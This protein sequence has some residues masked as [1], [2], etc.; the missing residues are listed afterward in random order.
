VAWVACAR[1]TGSDFAESAASRC[2]EPGF[3]KSCCWRD[4]ESW[5]DGLRDSFGVVATFGNAREEAALAAVGRAFGIRASSLADDDCARAAVM[6]CAALVAWFDAAMDVE[7]AACDAA[8]LL[9]TGS[10]GDTS[11]GSCSEN[12]RLSAVNG[13]GLA[14]SGLGIEM[15]AE[16]S[17]LSA[18][19]A[20]SEV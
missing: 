17:E 11:F 4:A 16:K 15:L 12:A 10:A 20:G 3:E 6:G 7:S 9:K 2:G 14:E 5:D 1:A 8:G 19:L 13:S 18:D